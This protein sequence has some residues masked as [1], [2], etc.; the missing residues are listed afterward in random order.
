MRILSRLANRDLLPKQS[1]KLPSLSI[2]EFEINKAMQMQKSGT[3]KRKQRRGH[4]AKRQQPSTKSDGARIG[5][6][7]T[8]TR[9]AR[10]AFKRGYCF[11]M[12]KL[13][14]RVRVHLLSI[15]L[16]RMEVSH[17]LL[18]CT[19]QLLTVTIF[20]RRSRSCRG[21]AAADESHAISPAAPYRRCS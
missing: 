9:P 16:C 12:G 6:G 10:A 17:S 8:Q 13:F 2:E 1:T 3:F 11:G 21:G 15:S 18:R 14:G 4:I 7:A 19:C 20:D 5:R